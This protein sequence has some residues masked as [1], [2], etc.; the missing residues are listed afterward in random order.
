[1]IL[2]DTSIWIEHFRKNER[3]LANLLLENRVCI[4][5]MIIGEIACGSL[6][7][8]GEVLPLLKLLPFIEVASYDEV[9]HFVDKRR[10][11][12]QGVGWIDVN[13]LASCL[14]AGV[15][16]WTNDKSLRKVAQTLD[17]AC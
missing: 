16:I 5:P 4:H 17:L 7:Q 3:Q 8:R 15:T 1:M 9:M 13:L 6:R 10:V 2:A 14:I 11:F 12:G